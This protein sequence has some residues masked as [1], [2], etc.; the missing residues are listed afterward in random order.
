MLGN[1]YMHMFTCGCGE[2]GKQKKRSRFSTSRAARDSNM[3]GT[4]IQTRW[5]EWREMDGCPALISTEDVTCT[6]TRR[7]KDIRSQTSRQPSPFPSL[8]LFHFQ[9]TITLHH[10]PLPQFPS[11]SSFSCCPARAAPP[12]ARPYMSFPCVSLQ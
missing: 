7:D 10:L 5:R 6:H 12:A 8:L 1:V 2:R 9:R 11:S 3:Q 4:C